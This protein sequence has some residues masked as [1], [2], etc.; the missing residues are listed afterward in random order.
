MLFGTCPPIAGP[1]LP[2]APVVQALRGFARTSS[3]DEVASVLGPARTVLSALVPSLAAAGSE[4]PS[5]G[6]PLGLVFEHL[7]GVL[8]RL[9]LRHDLVI[10]VLDDIHWGGPTTWDLLAHLARNLAGVRVLAIA[11]YRRD[12]LDGRAAQLLVEL[13]RSPIVETVQLH[14]LPPADAEELVAELRPDLAPAAQRAITARAEGNPFYVEELSA[15]AGERGIPDTLR[16][17]LLAKLEG[18]PE[19]VI[20]VVRVAAVIGRLAGAELV[21]AVAGYPDEVAIAA[22]RRAVRVGLLKVEPQGPTGGYSLPHDLLRE[23]VYEELLP[24]ERS[25]L[26]GAVARALAAQPDPTRTNT[27]RA[28]ELATHWRESGD[29]VRAVPALLKAADAAQAGYAFVEAHRLYEHAF[30]SVAGAESPASGPK[31]GFKPATHDRGPEWAE[32][33]ARAAEAASLAGEPGRAIEHVDSAL[34]QAVGDPTVRLRWTERRARYLLEAG[35]DSESLEAYADLAS[36]ADEIA[37]DDRP[38]LFVARARALTLTGHYREAGEVA[39]AALQLA[40]DAH[41]TT[42]EWQALNL[43]GTSQA[44]AGRAEEGLQALAAAR[45]LSQAHRSDSMIRPRPSRIGEMLGGQLSAARGLER[46]GR[47]A[48]ALDAALEGAA[49]A[50]RLGAA[51]WRGELDLAAAW[52][53]Y[54]QGRWPEAR[55]RGEELVAGTAG[56][57]TLDAHVLLAQIAVGEGRWHD[58]ERHLADAEPAVLRTSHSDLVAGHLLAVAELA[59]WQRRWADG[60]SVVAE[61]LARLGESED[62]LSRAEL[63]GFGLRLEVELHAE[64]QMRRAGGEPASHGE[65][66]VRALGEVRA[67]LES[68]PANVLQAAAAAEFSRI[69]GSDP[70]LW[71][72]AVSAAERSSEPYTTAY[73]RWR[74]AEAQLAG[75]EGRAEA[76]AELRLAFAA[77]TGLAASPLVA[78]ITSLATRARVDLEP[79]MTDAPPKEMRAGGELGLSERELEVLALVA[80]G[81]TN[82]QIAEELFITEKTAGHHVSNILSK[83]GVVNRLEAAAIAHRAGVGDDSS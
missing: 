71:A 79:A 7:L 78:E 4:G 51:R 35:R 33:H 45:E 77:A 8:E 75:R 76:A 6:V 64:A 67:L 29:I 43:V 3:P 72:A 47:P 22:L 66:A 83:L 17:T 24:G 81:R 30:A 27:D 55:A 31:I 34:A 59:F 50:D 26:H 44:F 37:A 18:Q 69:A 21:M 10:L 40:R 2:L 36:R 15:A 12:G 41:R 70:E 23:V 28:I 62:R 57:A 25:R 82:R 58:A 32:I 13:Q 73:A 74:L 46:A 38:R 14:G 68:D 42:E 5:G 39:E 48:E 80:K 53:Q 54:R 63:C 20:R 9:S 19:E 65:A 56:S 16:A 11:T 60:A 61:G 1:D 52:Q 49:T